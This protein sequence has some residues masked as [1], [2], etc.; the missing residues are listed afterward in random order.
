MVNILSLMVGCLFLKN[1]ITYVTDFLLDYC[2]ENAR[3][4]EE[5]SGGD[6]DAVLDYDN[7]TMTKSKT[8]NHNWFFM[9]LGCKQNY[10]QI[11]IRNRQ[12]KLKPAKNGAT[13]KLRYAFTAVVLQK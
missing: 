5:S 2:D 3:K 11:I 13:K 6:H 1:K 10:N 8:W 12:M 4:I 7:K 9:N